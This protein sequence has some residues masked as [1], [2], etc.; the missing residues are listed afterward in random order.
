MPCKLKWRGFLPRIPNQKAAYNRLD[1]HNL[2][3]QAVAGT[4]QQSAYE[5][6][7]TRQ[8]YFTQDKQWLT[9]TDEGFFIHTCQC[10]GVSP[11]S[12]ITAA[13]DYFYMHTIIRLHLAS[14]SQEMQ[15]L[16]FF[17]NHTTKI[18]NLIIHTYT[19]LFVIVSTSEP[20]WSPQ[21]G[22]RLLCSWQTVN[23]LVSCHFRC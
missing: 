21:Y 5:P 15:Q 10:S 18:H 3:A 1:T 23:I 11:Q 22:V 8:S 19:A 7:C 16:L 13:S 6:I 4:W 2:M 12:N 20:G 9:S 17:E 14:Q